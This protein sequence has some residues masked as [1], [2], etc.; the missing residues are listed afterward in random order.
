MAPRHV[1]AAWLETQADDR[2]PHGSGPAQRG[3]F[4]SGRLTLR[5][6]AGAVSAPITFDAGGLNGE[7]AA[8]LA[9]TIPAGFAVEIDGRPL[10]STD[11]V[12]VRI[13]ARPL[14]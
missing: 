9:L 11:A 8:R 7:G 4:L 1:R 10:A 13:V 2:Q 12:G 5:T 6:A 14:A 3:G